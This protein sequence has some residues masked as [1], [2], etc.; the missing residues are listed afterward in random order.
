MVADRA[1]SVSKSQAGT[2]ACRLYGLVARQARK[3]VVFRRGPS[4]QVC[5]V[6]W[7]LATDRFEIGQWVKTRV[8]EQWCDVSPDAKYLVYLAD[9]YRSHGKQAFDAYTAVSQPP[10]FT[11]FALWR[12]VLIGLWMTNQTLVFEG[13]VPVSEYNWLP[14]RVRIRG[15]R[16]AD[17]TPIRNPPRRLRLLRD[18]WTYQ[19][20][21]LP[22][23][24]IDHKGNYLERF[25]PPI[26]ITK[27][28][29]CNFVL[30]DRLHARGPQ[31]HAGPGE[32]IELVVLKPDGTSAFAFNDAD[33][34]DFDN[35]GDLLFALKGCLYRLEADRIAEQ[36]DAAAAIASA[37]CLIDLS[38]LRFEAKRAPY[39]DSAGP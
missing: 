17:K 22:P 25:Q 9:D 7:D 1:Q 13:T 26:T 32:K 15:T 39:A 28:S 4:K 23:L 2:P 5:L 16:N 8:R 12:T 19:G 10:Y 18:G 30:E 3:V 27:K 37:K 6:L 14:S 33:W 31:R 11:A 29:V 38:P 36:A 20:K 21:A 35:N 34:A 24:E